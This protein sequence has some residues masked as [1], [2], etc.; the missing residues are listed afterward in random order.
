MRNAL[1]V[2]GPVPEHLLG[3]TLPAEHVWADHTVP[4]D[5]QSTWRRLS[6]ARPTAARDRAFYEAPLALN[7]LGDVQLG[8][9][10]RENDRLTDT[11]VTVRELERYAQFGGRT[12][13]DVTAIGAHRNWHEVRRIAGLTGLNIIVSTGW[14]SPRWVPELAARSIDDLTDELVHDLTVGEA[15]V[16]AGVIAQVDPLVLTEAGDLA[17]ATALGRAAAHTGAPLYLPHLTD[18]DATLALIDVV[19]G[20][21]AMPAQIALLG[22]TPH[23]A[24]SA[25][26]ERLAAQGISLCFDGVGRIPMVYTEVS[27]HEVALALM[28]FADRGHASQLLISPRISQRIGLTAFG[29]TG[30]AF[31]PEQFAPYLE[32]LGADPHFFDTLTSTNPARFLSR[33]EATA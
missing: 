27:D 8:R 2:N 19:C 15:G 30:Y 25:H 5:L 13:V 12:V 26:L 14:R 24:A 22:V 1:T 21:G 32:G 11:D 28:R 3:M 31:L 4:D 20:A 7:M 16:R 23:L 17:V 9:M 18:I 29:G 33:E 6:I 10:N